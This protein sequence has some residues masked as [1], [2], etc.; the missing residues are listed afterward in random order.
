[1]LVLDINRMSTLSFTISFIESNLFFEKL[2][3]S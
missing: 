2:M 1:M 3:L